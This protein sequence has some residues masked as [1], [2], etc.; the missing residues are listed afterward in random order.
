MNPPA[1]QIPA[2]YLFYI[3]VRLGGRFAARNSFER[4]FSPWRALIFWLRNQQKQGFY[5]LRKEIWERRAKL[6]SG[7]SLP[8]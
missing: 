6:S 8:E 5:R 7:P 2:N 4:L 1:E 3:A